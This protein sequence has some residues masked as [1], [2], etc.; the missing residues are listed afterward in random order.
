MSAP[1]VS[2]MITTYNRGAQVGGTIESVLAQTYRDFELVIVNNGSTDDTKDVLEKW[3]SEDARIRIFHQENL[4]MVGG[5]NSCIRHSKGDFL[6]I[7]DSDDFWYPKK[8]EIQVEAMA[9]SSKVGMTC[10]DFDAVSNGTV[11]EAKALKNS[12]HNWLRFK[13]NGDLFKNVAQVKGCEYA[14]GEIFSELLL[15]NLALPSSMMMSRQAIDASGFLLPGFGGLGEDFEYGLRISRKFDIGFI[16]SPL[17]RYTVGDPSQLSGG[18]KQQVGIAESYLK[19]FDDYVSKHRPEIAQ[20]DSVLKKHRAETLLW[21]GRALLQVG[22]K[23]EAR[24]RFIESLK[25][26]PT[27]KT[28]YKQVIKT[29]I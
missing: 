1:L 2:V 25:L 21:V 3:A 23:G 5:R 6:A 26:N 4:H 16:D 9:R 22:R 24:A 29:L 18:L 27:Q 12:Y 8:L 11:V 19:I 28:A 17:V 14:W 15:G 7:I 13:A 20:S 10:T